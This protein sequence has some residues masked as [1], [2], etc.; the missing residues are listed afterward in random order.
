MVNTPVLFIAFARPEYASQ[1]FNAIKKARPKKLYFYS[2]KAREDKPEEVKRNEEVRSLVKQIDWDCEVKTWFREDYVDVF[3]SLWGAID[4]I[5]D[6][7]KEAIVVEEDV[8]TCPAFYEY[9][10]AMVEKFRDND[11]VWI[12]SGDNATPEFNPKGLGYFPTRFADIFGWA[13]WADRWHSIDRRMEKWPEFRKSKA[14][15]DYYG[16]W[17]QRKIQRFYFDQV[18]N[19]Y[20]TYNPWDFVFNYNLA[21]N[22]AYSIMPF[23]NMVASIGVVGVNHKVALESPLSKIGIETEHFPFNMGEPPIISPT[24]FDGKYYVHFRIKRL[25]KRKLHKFLG[26]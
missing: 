21:L 13:S 23:V 4:W 11:K 2:N 19:N 9:M 7:E 26:L 1:S 24:S 22:N 17:L 5:F 14:F 8:V 25:V 15:H 12:V 10:D 3:T 16:N 20:E 18:Y 6:N